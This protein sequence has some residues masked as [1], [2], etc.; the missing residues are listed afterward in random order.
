[1]SRENRNVNEANE[2][3]NLFRITRINKR[4]RIMIIERERDRERETER[5]RDRETERER[6]KDKERERDKRAVR[7][8]MLKQTEGKQP[9]TKG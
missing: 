5:Q 7:S 6:D 4:K 2:A 1:M 9:V 3:K 8:F